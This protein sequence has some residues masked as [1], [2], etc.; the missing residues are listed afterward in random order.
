MKKC[1]S[2]L[3]ATIALSAIAFAQTTTS[4]ISGKITTTGGMP[5]A[6]ATVIATHTPSSTQYGTASDAGGAYRLNGMRVG[7]PYTVEIS[8]VGCTTVNYDGIRLE[9]GETK[10]IDASLNDSRDIETVVVKTYRYDTFRNGTASNFGNSVIEKMPTISRSIYDIARLTPEAMVSKD[11]GISI[12]GTNSRYNTFQIDGIVSNDIYGLTSSGTNGGLADANPIP[13]DAIDEIQVVVAPFDVRQ[14][15]FTGGGI[16]AVTK[17]GTNSFSGTAYTYYNNQDFYG[18]NTDSGTKLPKQSTQIYGISL[19][20]PI[21]RNKLFFFVN[22]EFDYNSSPSSFYAGYSPLSIT[23][24]DAQKIADRYMALTGYDGGGY[25][26]RN[27]VKKSGS[28][29]ARLDW[30]IDDRHNLTLRYNYLD[31]SMDNYANSAASFSFNGSAYA[32]SN[33]T[34]SLVGELNSRISQSVF[35]EFRIGYNRIIDGGESERLLPYVQINKLSDTDNSGRNNNIKVMIG[36]NPYNGMNHLEQNSVSISDNVSIYS[37]NH[38]ITVGTH[39]EIFTNDVTYVANAFGTYTYNTLQDFL[40]DNASSYM[41]NYPIGNP[42]IRTSSAQFGLYVQDEWSASRNF[43]LTYGI[44]ADI[45]VIFDTPNENPAFNASEIAQKY[46]IRTDSKPKVRIM[47]SPRI[48]FRWKA[49][50]RDEYTAVFRGGAG[51]FTGKVPFVWIKNCFSNTGTTQR[52]YALYNADTPAFGEEPDGETV[53]NP[54]IHLASPEF[55]YPQTFRANLAFEQSLRNGWRFAIDGIFSKTFNNMLIENLVAQDKGNR[56]YAVSAEMSNHDNTTVFYDSSAKSQFSSIYYLKNTDKGYSYSVSASVFKHFGF[57]MDISAAY[58]F[59]HSY[60]V[61]DG[62]SAQAPSN[63][64]KCYAAESNTE[65][66][67]YS[68]FDTPHKVTASVSYS[69]RYARYFGSTVSLIYQAYSGMRYSLTYYQN[70]IDANGDSCRGNMLMY[71]P[72]KS[73]LAAMNFESDEQRDCFDAFI[74]GDRYLRNHRGRYSERNA[75]QTPF[76]HH[77]DL[78]FAQ[79]FYFG[80]ATGRKLQLT[81]DILNFGN[82]LCKNWG[83]SYYQPNWKASPV[84]IYAL[85]DDGTGNKTP[86]YRYRGA[87]I[88]KDDLLS[89]WHI[90]IGARIAF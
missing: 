7:G 61:M 54:A 15:G 86:Q 27:V 28:L 62:I 6:G 25:G 59:G 47:L 14:S 34:H 50:E 73:E 63:W 29:V 68:L 79:D 45:P 13:L 69:K 55:K 52:G 16:N 89:R 2:T 46:G 23:A 21:V 8:Y 78:H 10:E 80:A 66:L 38:A 17:S 76:E 1:F 24:E 70:G 37:G 56:L 30:N 58:T 85:D 82:L 72:A 35:N 33:R 57:G 44:R 40:D 83:T 26:H 32:L 51:I 4:A 19:G 67:S 39:N 42:A 18:R 87:T 41:R 75:M 65:G 12:A 53:S 71:I 3:F 31:A 20:G 60:T 48:G 49:V 22:G 90:Q 9:L 36:T 43:T 11:G 64:G 81:L 88:S 5:L 77:L 84:E 74:E